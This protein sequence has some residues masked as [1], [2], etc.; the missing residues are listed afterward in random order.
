MIEDMTWDKEGGMVVII[1]GYQVLD[2]EATNINWVQRAMCV[3]IEEK[4]YLSC[5]WRLLF[6]F[7]KYILVC[8][9]RVENF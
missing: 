5:V 8:K 9:K 7:A 6:S 3:L 4:T 2:S 1:V